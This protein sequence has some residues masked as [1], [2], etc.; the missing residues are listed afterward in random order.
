MGGG[1]CA[2]PL[3]TMDIQDLHSDILKILEKHKYSLESSRIKIDELSKWALTVEKKLKIEKFN[4]VHITTEL[5]WAL[6]FTQISIGTALISGQKCTFPKGIKGTAYDES[7]LPDFVVI[8][9]IHFWYNVY[10]CWENL[11]RCWERMKR[12]MLFALYPDYEDKI[13]YN[14][15]ITKLSEDL[16]TKQYKEIKE[17]KDG[18]KYY[19][20]V[21]KM[22]NK[23]SHQESSPFKTVKYKG[24]LSRVRGSLGEYILKIDYESPNLLNVMQSVKSSYVRIVPNFEIIKKFITK[25]SEKK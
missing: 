2:R 3:G 20:K 16:G 12:I 24:D 7:Q 17:L 4:F 25:Y 5:F 10:Y 22:R 19:S 23:Y 11:Y 21:V 9:E 6:A 8:P 13:Y 1:L 18:L 14:G 15:L